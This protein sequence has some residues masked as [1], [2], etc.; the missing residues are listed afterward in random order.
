[1]F[2]SP[3]SSHQKDDRKKSMN[4]RDM[5]VG[6]PPLKTDFAVPITPVNYDCSNPKG[7]NNKF[8][9]NSDWRVI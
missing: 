6:I 8:T 4:R 1:M 2:F 9:S 7:K 5:S 3:S